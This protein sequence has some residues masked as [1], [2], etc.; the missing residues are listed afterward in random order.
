[1]SLDLAEMSEG[2]G[3][4]YE[5]ARMQLRRDVNELRLV[6]EVTL[7]RSSRLA[8]LVEKYS[9]DMKASRGERASDWARIAADTPGTTAQQCAVTPQ[10]PR[11]VWQ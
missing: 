7:I 10:N 2:P 8:G 3:P 9:E 11:T 5:M 6:A 1:M 4:D